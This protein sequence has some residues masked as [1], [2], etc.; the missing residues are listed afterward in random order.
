MADVIF[1]DECIPDFTIVQNGSNTPTFASSGTV[2][3][4]CCRRQ[5]FINVDSTD[6]LPSVTCPPVPPP[7]YPPTSV[8]TK[9]DF[10]KCFGSPIVVSSGVDFDDAIIDTQWYTSVSGSLFVDDDLLVS[11]NNQTAQRFQANQYLGSLPAALNQQC[12]FQPAI[13]PTNCNVAHTFP[14]ET[15]IAT[16]PEGQPWAFRAVD[17]HGGQLLMNGYIEARPTSAP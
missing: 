3:L 9:N 16:V 7:G 12:V 15:L 13:N 14:E 10:N 5:F 2:D 1:T 8:T 17:N 6:L 4:D 11:I